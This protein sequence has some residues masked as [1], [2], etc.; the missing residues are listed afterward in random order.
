MMRRNETYR[1][2]GADYFDQLDR[3]RTTKRLVRRLE[4]LGSSVKLSAGPEGP[5]PESRAPSQGFAQ[6][7]TLA[8][9]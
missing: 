7:H 4:R 8:F 3:E 1:E 2:F 9:S 6:A 5:M